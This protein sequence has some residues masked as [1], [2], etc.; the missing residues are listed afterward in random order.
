MFD[1]A[2]YKIKKN[3]VITMTNQC[4]GKNVQE[5]EN[6][7]KTLKSL[8]ELIGIKLLDSVFNFGFVDHI[9]DKLGILV[10]VKWF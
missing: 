6:A 2:L 10:H 3:F 8:K 9:R 7:I 4:V 5:I 1:F